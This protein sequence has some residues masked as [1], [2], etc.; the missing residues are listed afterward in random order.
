[1]LAGALVSA[2]LAAPAAQ[3]FD[4][5]ITRTAHGIP[6]IRSSTFTGAGYGY[7]YAFAQDNL[8]EIAE[9]YA[10]VNAQRSRFFGP[11]RSY[12]QR[13]NGTTV[14]NLNS[15]FFYQLAIDTKIVEKLVDQP[16]PHGPRS[17][18]KAAVR[19]YVAGYNRY[20]RRIGVDNIRDPRCRGKEWVRPIREIDVYRRFWQLGILASQGVVVDSIGSS[21]PPPANAG[22]APAFDVSRIDPQKFRESLLGIGS[23][24]VALGKDAT[25]NGRGMVLGNPHFPWDGPERFYHAHI[26]VPR[27]LD[28]AGASLFGVPVILIGTT[29]GLAWSHTVSTAFRFTPVELR[30]VPGSP[31]T[32]LVDGERREMTRDRVVV[33]LGGGEQRTRI[34]YSSEYGPIF[35]SILGLPAFPW[36]PATAYS[37]QDANAGNF[38]YLNHFLETNM[39]QNV[40]EYDRILR[41]DQG[42]P[43]V[44]S[45]AAD[46][47]GKAYY[48][49]L[50]VV[51][52]VT[53]AKAQECNT[54]LGM[55]T[56]QALRLPVLDGSRSACRW[57]NDP[58]AAAPGIFGPSHLPS[59][60]RDD[61]VTNSND[62]Y[63]LSNPAQPIEGFA[64]IIG[65]ERTART[66]RTRLGLKIVMQRLAGADGLPGRKFSLGQLQD[67]VFNNRQHAGELWRDE[68]VAMCR[69]TPGDQTACD[70]LAGWN[71][72][73]DLGSRGAV[74]FRR[75][76]SRALATGVQPYSVPFDPADPV[77]TPRGLNTS[78]PQVRDALVE[79]VQDLQSANIPFDAPL[80]RWQYERRGDDRIPIHGGPG[81]VGDFNAINVSWVAG[82]GYP[83]VPH[84][85]SFVQAVELT[86]GCPE[87]RTIL[88]YSQS[89]NPV[90]PWF[91]DQTRMFSKKEW[92]DFPFCRRDVRAAA[93]SV[94]RLR[95]RR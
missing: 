71:V 55:A 38:R 66:L 32:Y 31:T 29:R 37:I 42:I 45:I 10:T 61:F 64:R 7:G 63:W 86:S 85:S 79:A 50:S 17:E 9:V 80:G 70:A 14:N 30:L 72:K 89:T 23:N 69:Q 35:T 25:D 19:G 68:L 88:T 18:V 48:A 40:V 44:N 46:S 22:P 3:A 67:A 78:N 41:R 49:D 82:K 16:A 73:D 34:L 43:W 47:T 54:A 33:D 57:A 2:A 6:H 28:A 95:A 81:T 1:V 60:V 36:T 90:S 76:A 75:F 27:K 74:L 53:D 91:D 84:G 94:K 5:T 51:P 58:D 12:Q 20:L 8:C 11:N 77:N 24:A 26:T 93:L 13:G 56:F 52:N 21:Q 4:V 59:L 39:A 15:D 65:D 87:V 83:D 92:V 62:S